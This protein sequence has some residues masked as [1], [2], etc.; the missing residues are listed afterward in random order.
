MAVAATVAM[1]YSTEEAPASNTTYGNRPLGG[2][3]QTAR[4]WVLVRSVASL[5]A[6]PGQ[7]CG[8][9]P[10]VRTILLALGCGP[11]GPT[12]GRSWSP[13]RV[14]RL[15]S[16]DALI[17]RAGSLCFEE[18]PCPIHLYVLAPSRSHD[19]AVAATTVTCLCGWTVPRPLPE[20]TA[21][22]SPKRSNSNAPVST[23][24]PAKTEATVHQ[25]TSSLHAATAIT[26]GT[27]TDQRPHLLPRRTSAK[28]EC[29]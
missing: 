28:W 11:C 27:S 7:L 25:A 26:I 19:R 12:L 6:G 10:L 8:L 14:S 23:W 17:G 29:R 18:P 22:P 5:T 9:G 24:S 20:R 21:S 15:V 1:R 2:I 4:P 16:R 3:T 13:A